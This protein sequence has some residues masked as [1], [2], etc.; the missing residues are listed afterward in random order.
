MAEPPPPPA[1]PGADGSVPKTGEGL[2]RNGFVAIVVAAVVVVALV[3]VGFLST[4]PDLGEE[5]GVATTTVPGSRKVCADVGKVNDDG[6]IEEGEVRCGTSTDWRERITDVSEFCGGV[7]LLNDYIEQWVE[8]AESS[9]TLAPVKTWSLERTPAYD[10]SV[11][12]LQG[13]TKGETRVDVDKVVAE[14]DRQKVELFAATSPEQFDVFYGTDRVSGVRSVG[15]ELTRL[16]M[17]RTE[18]C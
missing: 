6:T 9:P 16:D 17:A 1:P 8:L 10:A 3:T 18:H 5:R 15:D 2:S 12:R 13:A 7:A 4:G 11:A 14:L